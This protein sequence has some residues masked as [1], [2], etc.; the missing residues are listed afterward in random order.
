[1]RR[2]NSF[3][4]EGKRRSE[5]RP[6]GKDAVCAT[7]ALKGNPDY[8]FSSSLDWS[9]RIRDFI[10]HRMTSTVPLRINWKNQQ[11]TAVIFA[12]IFWAPN[13]GDCVLKYK[14]RMDFYKS[15]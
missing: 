15:S 2:P 11:F 10:A 7:F 14:F 9:A 6:W 8:L 3:P 5:E 4:G 13:L 1:M 12:R